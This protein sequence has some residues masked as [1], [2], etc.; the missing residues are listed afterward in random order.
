MSEPVTSLLEQ[1]LVEQQAQTELLRRI[2]S[3]QVVLIQALA[4]EQG[5]D[6]DSATLTY[7]DGTPCR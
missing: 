4:A 2:A 7:M 3:N 5:E 1:M 6:L